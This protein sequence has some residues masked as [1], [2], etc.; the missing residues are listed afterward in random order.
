MAVIGLQC[1]AF[2]KDMHQCRSTYALPPHLETRIGL[3]HVTRGRCFPLCGNVACGLAF[4][5]EHTLDLMNE[6][7]KLYRLRLLRLTSSQSQKLLGRHWNGLPHSLICGGR[8]VHFTFC[9]H[10]QWIN[11][12]P[13]SSSDPNPLITRILNKILNLIRLIDSSMLVA[14]L[15]YQ[16]ATNAMMLYDTEEADWEADVTI[17]TLR[18]IA[19]KAHTTSQSVMEGFREIKQEVYKI[20]ASTKD[21]MFI[22]L[23]PPDPSHCTSNL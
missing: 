9:P 14:Q 18:D 1:S 5:E 7:M 13:N 3:P 19:G 20:A 17:D 6:E 11:Y 16:L 15:G 4:H 10:S 22:V 8:S 2:Y 21:D 12:L 23:V